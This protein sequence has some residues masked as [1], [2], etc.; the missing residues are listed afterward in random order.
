MLLLCAATSAAEVLVADYDGDMEFTDPDGGGLVGSEYAIL[1]A[2]DAN[3]RDYDLVT[4]IGDLAGYDI[5][6]VLL[7]TFP[8]SRSLDYS[9]QQALLD[10]GRWRGLYMEGGDVG[11]D[12]SPA[13]LWDLFG[14]RYLYDGEPT[15]DGNVETVKGIS[16]TL[17]AG[18]AFDCPGYQTEPSDNYLD[19]ITNDGG[20]VIFTSTPM[21]HV[22]NARTVAHSGDGHHRAVVSTFLFGALADGSSTK[23]ELM[24]R[25]L[26]YLGETM[27]VEEMS[28]GEIKAGYR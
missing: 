10:F 27:P 6:F 1:N 25:L 12:Y 7:G 19:E 2:L 17:T 16:G 5:V 21:G 23:E 18:L 26:D 15:E 13:P 22:S 11:Y 9:D 14:A 20:T 3:G 8:A 28:W 24:G 4:D